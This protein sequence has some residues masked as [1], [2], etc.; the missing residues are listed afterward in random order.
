MRLWNYVICG[1]LASTSAMSSMPGEEME[2]SST[3]ATT[4]G[5]K[6]KVYEKLFFGGDVRHGMFLNPSDIDAPAFDS[7]PS[8]L[9]RPDQENEAVGS[10][11]TKEHTYK[12][13]KGNSWYVIERSQSDTLQPVFSTLQSAP[14]GVS[15]FVFEG[16]RVVR[17]TAFKSPAH[18]GVLYTIRNNKDVG[19][20]VLFQF[21]LYPFE[22]AG[23]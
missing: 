11:Y 6:A 14:Q 15:D 10:F 1:I 3:A 13:Q 8:F 18:Y 21:T 7:I 19:K 12:D 22:R 4:S 23:S 20:P 9:A 16:V 17:S 2:G 5:F